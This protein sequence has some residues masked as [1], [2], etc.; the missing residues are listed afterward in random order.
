MPPRRPLQADGDHTE[1]RVYSFSWGQVSPDYRSF[2]HA[3]CHTLRASTDVVLGEPQAGMPKTL[4]SP[5]VHS[6]WHHWQYKCAT[7]CQVCSGAAHATRSLHVQALAKG[8][9]AQCRTCCCIALSAVNSGSAERVL[10]FHTTWSFSPRALRP[11]NCQMHDAVHLQLQVGSTKACSQPEYLRQCC[12]VQGMAIGNIA[13]HD[14]AQRHPSNLALS[15]LSLT[16][17]AAYMHAQRTNIL[18]VC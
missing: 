17:S 11:G 2:A 3:C 16:R 15:P 12:Q 10:V 6:Q 8:S 9:A 5:G 18:A 14:H 7:S 1:Q 13:M 4:S